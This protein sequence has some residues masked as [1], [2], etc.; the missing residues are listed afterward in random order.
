MLRWAP[1]L[2]TRFS[3]AVK[4]H[5]TS[6]LLLPGGVKVDSLGVVHVFWSS[7]S[8]NYDAFL[9]RSDPMPLAELGG[10]AAQGPGSGHDL[11]SWLPTFEIFDLANPPELP[12]AGGLDVTPEGTAV[13]IWTNISVSSSER[14]PTGFVIHRG[15]KRGKRFHTLG[16]QVPWSEVG[17]VLFRPPH[18]FVFSGHTFLPGGPYMQRFDLESGSAELPRSIAESTGDAL[19]FGKGVA[20]GPNGEICVVYSYWPLG[21][22]NFSIRFVMSADRGANWTKPITLNDPLYGARGA[23]MEIAPDGTIHVIYLSS[24][25]YY[26]RARLN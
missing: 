16:T 3:A 15:E 20:E 13:A 8:V 4:L 12:I 9:A 17:P 6:V 25:L 11:G 23:S 2:S 22:G 7:P 1:A 14:H 5:P 21:G 10:G 18:L 19:A 24:H 26:T